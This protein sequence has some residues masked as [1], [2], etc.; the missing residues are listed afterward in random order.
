MYSLFIFFLELLFIKWWLD[1]SEIRKY[2]K[3]VTI[4]GTIGL[5]AYGLFVSCIDRKRINYPLARE[6]A[7]VAN[8]CMTFVMWLVMNNI[9][10]IREHNPKFIKAGSWFLKKCFC[11]VHLI[12]FSLGVAMYLGEI[13]INNKPTIEYTLVISTTLF[14]WSFTRDFKKFKMDVDNGRN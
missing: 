10:R 4:F 2:T 5:M 12:A 8:L 3:M 14:L 6:S 11:F 13:D 7:N 9:R 1:T